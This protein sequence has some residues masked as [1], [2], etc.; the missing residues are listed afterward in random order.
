M[1]WFGMCVY[2]VSARTRS[3]GTFCVVTAVVSWVMAKPG[4]AMGCPRGVVWPAPWEGCCL[5]PP[6][7][8]LSPF[9]GAGACVPRLLPAAGRLQAQQAE[10]A[11][12]GRA[13]GR[14][15]QRGRRPYPMQLTAWAPGG[16]LATVAYMARPGWTLHGCVSP[17]HGCP[18]VFAQLL[19]VGGSPTCVCVLPT[20]LRLPPR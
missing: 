20:E 6:K 7:V 4:K 11:G 12:P 8:A 17:S 13:A 14:A 16:M 10:V 2:S 19:F 9:P 15:G 3:P 5:A 18:G 1:L